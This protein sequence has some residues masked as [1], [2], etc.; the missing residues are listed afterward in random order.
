M[1]ETTQRVI[2]RRLFQELTASVTL[3]APFADR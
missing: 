1:G 3:I 2:P